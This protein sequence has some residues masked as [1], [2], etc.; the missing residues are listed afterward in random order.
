MP[1]RFGYAQGRLSFE[2]EGSG[3]GAQRGQSYSVIPITSSAGREGSCFFGLVLGALVISPQ[4]PQGEEG[5]K[6]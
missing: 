1:A 4:K 5:E 3:S 6:T 2:F